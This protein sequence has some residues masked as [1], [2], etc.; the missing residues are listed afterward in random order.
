MNIGSRPRHAGVPGR[1]GVPW[2]SRRV[3]ELSPWR[4]ALG[5]AP[6]TRAVLFGADL[7]TS[8]TVLT[9][10]VLTEPIALYRDLAIGMLYAAGVGG[11]TALGT[12]K[13]AQ[14][15]AGRSRGG[16][17]QLLSSC[18]RGRRSAGTCPVTSQV[19]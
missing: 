10:R 9:D 19:S 4:F 1:I 17:K 8:T 2:N 3:E 6:V 16:R 13:I 11:G 18:Q 15:S 14:H 12:I 5:G 7:L